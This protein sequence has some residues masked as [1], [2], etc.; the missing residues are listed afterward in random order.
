[1]NTTSFSLLRRLQQPAAEEAWARF[2]RLYTPL[3]YHWARGVHLPASEASDLVQDVLTLLVQKLPEFTYD[4]TKSFRGWLRT[5][6]LNKWRENQRRRT[7]PVEPGRQDELANLPSPASAAVF[8]E[9]EYQKYLV[10]RALELMQAEFQPPTWKA[11]WAC[12]VEGRPAAAVAGELGMTLNAVYL[13]KS[14]VL[15]RLHQELK[16]LLD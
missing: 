11:C 15:R 13:A 4:Q 16:G 5:V 1:M 14:R 3:L 8:E 9:A 12:V 7:V 6:T 10:H 2:V